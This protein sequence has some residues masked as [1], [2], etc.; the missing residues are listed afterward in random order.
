MSFQVWG[1]L[2]MMLFGLYGTARANRVDGDTT[3]TVKAIPQPTDDQYR[4]ITN[5]FW[6]N[7]FVFGNVGG[8]AYFGDYAGRG[9][10]SGRLSPDLFVGA[11]K[12]FSPGIGAKIQFGGF[13]SRSYSEEKTPY[14]YGEQLTA[15]DGTPYWKAKIKWWDLSIHAM[16]NLSRLICGYEGIGSDKLMNQFILSAGIGA[17]HHW[18]IGPQANEFSGIGRAHV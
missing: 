8:H 5:R 16:F 11:G 9:K 7:W 17:V 12:W 1:I 4:V 15:S 3:V 6:D 2:G 13:R 18:D 10:F 14:V